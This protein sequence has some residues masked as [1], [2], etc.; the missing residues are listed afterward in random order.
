MCNIDQYPH[1]HLFMTVKGAQTKPSLFPI[2]TVPTDL[3]LA[4][5]QLLQNMQSFP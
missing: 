4:L 3:T 1:N 2:S 5:L